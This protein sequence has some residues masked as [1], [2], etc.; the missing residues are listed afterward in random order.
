MKNKTK[1][2]V[3]T[4]AELLSLHNRG[5]K[6]ASCLFAAVLGLVNVARAAEYSW[7]GDGGD[8]LWSTKGNWVDELIPTS[9][10]VIKP[11]KNISFFVDLENETH[12]VSKLDFSSAYNTSQLKYPSVQLSNGTLVL[13]NGLDDSTANR[14]DLDSGVM[15]ENSTCPFKLT[16]ATLRVKTKFK[17]GCSRSQGY[18]FSVYNGSSL[19]LDHVNLYDKFSW[20]KVFPGGTADF[21]FGTTVQKNG[22]STSRST[23]SNEGGTFSF[24]AGFTLNRTAQAGWSKRAS[25]RLQQKSGIMN[26]GG[27]VSLGNA[28]GSE[29]NAM[30]LYFQWFGGTVHALSNVTF[31]VDARYKYGSSE[32]Q[33]SFVQSNS[34]VTAEVDSGKVMDM[35]GITVREGVSLVKTGAGSLV[36]ADV[37]HSLFLNAG[38]ISFADNTVTDMGV[39]QVG[40][41]TSFAFANVN[42][43]LATLGGNEGVITIAKPGLTIGAIA[44]NAP[45]T[46]TFTV[47]IA[48]FSEGDTIVSTTDATLRA[49]IK[50]DLTPEFADAGVGLV[51][52]G[53]A[54]LVGAP[55]Y[56]FDSTTVTDLNDPS[57][58][59]S[60]LP[61][62]GKDV[63]VSGAGVHAVVS[64]DLTNVWNSITVQDGASIEIAV[65][66][67]SIPDLVLK[68]SALLT[69]SANFTP[70]PIST[71]VVGNAFPTLIV[72][73]GATLTVPAGQKF[74]NVHLV[75]CEGAT[76]T[77]SGDGPLVFGYATANETAYFAMHATN[78]TITAL[79]SAGT[80]KAARID[81]AS[82]ASGG[83]VLVEGD[84]ILKDSTI[85]Y[86]GKDGFAFGLNKPTS[87]SFRVVADNTPLDIGQDTYIAGGANLVLTN[88]S[89]LFRRRRNTG[90]HDGDPT[91]TY[92]IYIQDI[93][94]ITLVDG[95]EVRTTVTKANATDSNGCFGSGVVSLR[96]AE[97]GFV[98]IE[99]LEGGVGCWWRTYGD[100]TGVIR[101][102]GGIQKVFRGH[103]WGTVLGGNRSRIFNKLKGV[104]IVGGTILQI[105]GFHDNYGDN[106]DT[107]HPF[108]IDSPFTGT[109]DVV[110]TNTWSGKTC[111]PRFISAANT[112]TGTIKA[113]P[114]AG[115]ASAVI[116]FANGANWAGTVVANGK[117]KLEDSTTVPN[118]VS[119]GA[120]D[121]QT[122]V[123]VRVWKGNDVVATNDILNVGTYL[124]NGGKLV[125]TIVGEGEFVI[126]DSFCVGT[127]GKSG[128]LPRLPAGWFAKRTVIDGDEVHDL[129]TL[130]RGVGLQVIVR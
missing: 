71:L 124:N 118:M 22:D 68:G 120:L 38:A 49:K 70:V 96:P 107:M 25:F 69:V 97:D 101:Y 26:L 59:Q 98:G 104:D 80:E 81:F 21:T 14:N 66:D 24:P 18:L 76:L 50:A 119:F 3:K 53:D 114:C 115:N 126:G 99:V 8:T 19:I 67:L 58:W 87:S 91:D 28:S 112:C 5:A 13:T 52:S 111:E 51:E 29:S 37:P 40:A 54:L 45:L 16:N 103:W 89:V 83:E 6:T 117:L 27:N 123:S 88:N 62:A 11:A 15:G 94:K 31:N 121:L 10:D 9:E 108:Y 82:P 17:S 34:V 73:A 77:E 56:V 130:K 39:L 4:F 33:E 12:T 128:T 93:G 60:G 109:G 122:D 30:G 85:T 42:T 75:L 116:Y 110:V 23:W 36:V 7:T 125:P 74:S 86:R 84:I 32:A 72:S 57:G 20:I 65:A 63:I 127:I 46:G 105:V 43:T 1:M 44:E 129:L 95:G 90:S 113:V 100:N 2:M 35:S 64:A 92:N 102:A 47:A 48:A 106:D 55:S 78:A 61:A 79:N 41:G